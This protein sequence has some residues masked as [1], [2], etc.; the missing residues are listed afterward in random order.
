MEES[1]KYVS[2]QEKRMRKNKSLDVRGTRTLNL[3]LADA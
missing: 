1:A 2:S 3:S